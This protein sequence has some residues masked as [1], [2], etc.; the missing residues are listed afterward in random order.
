MQREPVSLFEHNHAGE[1]SGTITGAARPQ[2]RLLASSG[3]SLLR[4]QGPLGVVVLGRVSSSLPALC[5]VVQ[6][7]LILVTAFAISVD[8]MIRNII[9][10]RGEQMNIQ[11]TL[12]TILGFSLLTGCSFSISSPSTPPPPTLTQ[13]AI[14][15]PTQIR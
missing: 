11:K 1:C 14:G 7:V 3:V 5:T 10:N 2:L 13:L 15:L 9:V 4:L 8:Y 12:M 6:H